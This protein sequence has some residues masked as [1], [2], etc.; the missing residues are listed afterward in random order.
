[1]HLRPPWDTGCGWG[2]HFRRPSRVPGLG[3]PLIWRPSL[4]PA[5]EAGSLPSALKMLA[6][7]YADGNRFARVYLAALAYPVLL[8]CVSA[9]VL[10]LI[11]FFVAPSLA[12]LFA[13]WRNPRRLRSAP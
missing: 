7:S 3:C 1:M 9:V 5:K 12:G 13:R 8:L 4:G 11:A 10:A 6:T 2:A